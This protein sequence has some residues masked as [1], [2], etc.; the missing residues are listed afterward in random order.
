MGFDWDRVDDVYPKVAEELE[1]VRRAAGGSGDV[2][3]EVGDLLFACVNVARHLG[4][5]P[6]AALRAA[7]AKFRDRFVAVEA[8]ASER[9]I[10]MNSSDLT[11]LDRLW[12]EVKA[13]ET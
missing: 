5:D 10:D 2:A 13:R 7:T 6:E 8:L 11:T 3:E 4:A 9:G 1:E 12:D